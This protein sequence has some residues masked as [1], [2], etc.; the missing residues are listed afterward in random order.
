MQCVNP[1][2]RSPLSRYAQGVRKRPPAGG[3]PTGFQSCREPASKTEVKCCTE[4]KQGRLRPRFLM[5]GVSPCF[6]LPLAMRRPLSGVLRFL[7]SGGCAYAGER[8]PGA[9]TNRLAGFQERDRQVA[10]LASRWAASRYPVRCRA[11]GKEM[12]SLRNNRAV[13]ALAGEEPRASVQLH[14]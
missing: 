4:I 13:A 14:G 8:I 1:R 10:Q 12:P 3:R 7:N 9:A 11:A 2:L 6:G 5:Q